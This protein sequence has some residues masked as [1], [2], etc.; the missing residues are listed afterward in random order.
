M[1]KEIIK[2]IRRTLILVHEQLS[3]IAVD[4]Y[5]EKRLKKE[6]QMIANLASDVQKTQIQ[7]S[8]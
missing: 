6:F 3:D 5:G 4:I 8:K 1:S 7:L 2:R